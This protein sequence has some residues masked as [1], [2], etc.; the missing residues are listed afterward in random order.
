MRTFKILISIPLIISSIVLAET[1]KDTTTITFYGGDRLESTG[2]QP[3]I[4]NLRL[5]AEKIIRPSLLPLEL[6]SI[7]MR[8]EANFIQNQVQIKEFFILISWSPQLQLQLGQ[9]VGPFT[10]QLLPSSIEY[11][12]SYTPIYTINQKMYINGVQLYLKIP[13]NSIH[14][15]YYGDNNRGQ[16]SWQIADE[17]KFGCITVITGIG[18]MPDSLLN[19]QILEEV[20][21]SAG[22]QLSSD[23]AII[24]RSGN[25]WQ[26]YQIN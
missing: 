20:I 2:N 23:M 13:N 25:Q 19:N 16:S 18:S 15:G 12:P 4:D 7:T 11:I 24:T 22:K 8:A 9:Y 21:I 1:V 3:V 10:H 14:V 5:R 17:I 6:Q 26:K